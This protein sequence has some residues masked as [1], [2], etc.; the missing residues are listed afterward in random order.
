[1][2]ISEQ[3]QDIVLR[4]SSEQKTD[5]SFQQI[6]QKAD[7]A[8]I[9]DS[10]PVRKI[11]IQKAIVVR[12]AAIDTISVCKRNIIS[13]ISFS[14][15]AN[16]ITRI[17][18]PFHNGF[19]WSFMEANMENELK[20]KQ[21]LSNQLK[22][23]KEIPV[24]HFHDDWILIL[25]LAGAFVYTLIHTIS[26]KLFP[27]ITQ[28]FLLRGINDPASRDI[29]ELFHWQ[30]TLLNLISFI[31]IA[32]FS[33][34]TA[35]Y[36]DLIPNNISG[37]LFW[38]I[39]LGVIVA[40]VSSRHILCEVTGRI[41]DEPDTFREY[42]FAVYHSYR[43]SGIILFIIVIFISYTSIFPQKPLLITGFISAGVFYLIRVVHLFL[44][45]IKRK[46]SILYL[47]LYLCALEFLPVM[48]L[49]KYFTGLF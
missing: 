6:I 15:T 23:G 25:I 41:S 36:Y 39:A 33:Y 31:N 14:D 34:C 1:M 12:P 49:L 9:S 29:Q 28:F 42:I 24:R 16:I 19:P 2:I 21:A 11:H 13:D 18:Q 37:F 30:S 40:A 32:L 8:K 48:V 3:E 17:E 4:D 20:E 43:Y 46:I 35:S 22:E 44:I 5:T 26:K 10:L 27:E 38:L 47:I 45:F 7:S